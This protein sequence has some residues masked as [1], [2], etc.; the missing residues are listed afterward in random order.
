MAKKNLNW[1]IPLTAGV[2]LGAGLGVLFATE[3]GRKTR[4]RIRQGFENESEKLRDR[5]GELDKELKTK[6]KKARKSLQNNLEQLSADSQNK[7]QNAIRELKQKLENLT[8][9]QSK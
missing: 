2:A 8:V 4:K 3:Q 6:A 7:T 1:L 5:L 9:A